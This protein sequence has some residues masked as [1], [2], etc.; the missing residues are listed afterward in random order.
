MGKDPKRDP[1][2]AIVTIIGVSHG[3]NGSIGEELDSGRVVLCIQFSD[4]QTIL[5]ERKL[6]IRAAIHLLYS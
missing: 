3:L 4:L 6:S 5:E 1:G 2:L